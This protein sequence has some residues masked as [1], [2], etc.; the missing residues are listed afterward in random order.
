[1]LL[2]CTGPLASVPVT[3]AIVDGEPSQAA[4]SRK[5]TREIPFSF[6]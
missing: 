3:A 1:M 2:A 4:L 6:C 5:G